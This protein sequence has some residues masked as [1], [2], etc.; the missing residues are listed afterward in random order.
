M[1]PLMIK[2]LLIRNDTIGIPG[3]MWDMRLMIPMLPMIHRTPMIYFNIKSEQGA[4]H[5]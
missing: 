1:V 2:F 4:S 5:D 3:V